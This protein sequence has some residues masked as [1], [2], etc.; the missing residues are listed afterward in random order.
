MTSISWQRKAE[1]QD[2]QCKWHRIY[3]RQSSNKL[4]AACMAVIALRRKDR[5]EFFGTGQAQ[6]ENA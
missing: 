6:T 3:T 2:L 1:Q 5:T 4:I